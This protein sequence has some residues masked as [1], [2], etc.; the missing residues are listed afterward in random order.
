VKRG[1]NIALELGKTGKTGDDREL[2]M[3]I[4]DLKDW[5]L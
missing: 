2:A 4:K 3:M 5:A 1:M